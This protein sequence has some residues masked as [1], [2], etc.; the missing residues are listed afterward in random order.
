ME[1]NENKTLNALIRFVFFPML[2]ILVTASIIWLFSSVR[3]FASMYVSSDYYQ[4]D[5]AKK[6]QNETQTRFETFSKNFVSEKEFLDCKKQTEETLKRIECQNGKTVDK[7][8]D[9]DKFLR[10]YFSRAARTHTDVRGSAPAQRTTR[11]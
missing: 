1:C 3:S 2:V 5:I 9:L 8:E 4:T 7:L 11:P 10:D 6:V